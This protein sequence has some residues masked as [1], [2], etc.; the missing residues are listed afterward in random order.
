MIVGAGIVHN[1]A[2]AGVPDALNNA[3]E[4]IVGGPNAYGQLA[5]ILGLVVCIVLGFTM[6]ARHQT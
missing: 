3:G 5:V 6:R 2:L 1:F 4:L